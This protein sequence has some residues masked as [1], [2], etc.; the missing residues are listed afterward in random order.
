MQIEAENRSEVIRFHAQNPMMTE[1][2]TAGPT[3]KAIPVQDWA[4]NITAKIHV[5]N[6]LV[7][8]RDDPPFRSAGINSTPTLMR[9][10]EGT[11]FIE[12]PFAS[13][14][15]C[16]PSKHTKLRGYVWKTLDE[17]FG[18]RIT[19]SIDTSDD[20]LSKVSKPPRPDTIVVQ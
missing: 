19:T 2:D 4:K 8:V 6:D 11:D 3:R 10:P 16:N 18:F 1:S 17:P 20:F 15:V 9:H 13:Q 12:W 5:G 7:A 14:Q